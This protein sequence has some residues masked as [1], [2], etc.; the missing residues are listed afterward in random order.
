RQFRIGEHAE[1]HDAIVRGSIAALQVVT[2]DA[3]V[4]IGDVCELRT[5]RAIAHRPHVGCGRLQP[6]VYLD[7]AAPV[8]LDA[9]LLESDSLRIRR[10]T[11]GDEKIGT[12][13]DPFTR[14]VF[15]VNP[16]ILA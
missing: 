6:V 14:A 10:P 9:D 16:N 8:E 13:D 3:E 11:D 15:Y 4:V 12:F 5:A 7:I 1:R 2:H